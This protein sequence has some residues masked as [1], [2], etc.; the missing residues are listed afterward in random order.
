ME[1]HEGHRNICGDFAV[2][3]RSV[4]LSTGVFR[5]RIVF[6]PGYFINFKGL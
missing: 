2:Q 3:G 1:I 4:W 6:D 5:R